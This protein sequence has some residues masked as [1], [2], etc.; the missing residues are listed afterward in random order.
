MRLEA[1]LWFFAFAS[2]T[3]VAQ[4]PGYPTPGI[5][6]ASPFPANVKQYL[7]LSDDQAL[8]ITALNEQFSQGLGAKMQRQIQLQMEISRETS[9]EALDPIAIG[10]RYVELEQIRR[11]IERERAGI[12]ATVQTI[13]NDEQKGKLVALQQVIRDYP[14]ACAAIA[15]NIMNIP[16]LA[17]ANPNLSSGG[18]TGSFASVLLAPSAACQIPSVVTRQAGVVP[19]PVSPQP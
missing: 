11:E 1:L 16:P 4:V 14:V 6:R 15:Q 2:S 9:G 12:V 5:P 8:Q 17:T 3:T 18:L 10:T 7:A 13:L 19:V